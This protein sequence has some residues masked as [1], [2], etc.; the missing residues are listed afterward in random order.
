ML[1]YFSVGD[2]FCVTLQANLLA[3]REL[4]KRRVHILVPHAQKTGALNEQTHD[5]ISWFLSWFPKQYSFFLLHNNAKVK[6]SWAS[7][8]KEIGLHYR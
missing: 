2:N 3:E 6:N 4:G 1:I 8:K 7:A 5:S